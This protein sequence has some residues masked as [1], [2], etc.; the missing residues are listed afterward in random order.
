MR[1]KLN[2]M[3]WFLL[4]GKCLH[5][6]ILA[7]SAGIPMNFYGLFAAFIQ[8]LIPVFPI[9]AKL[10]RPKKKNLAILA[11]LQKRKKHAFS[12]L[13][14]FIQKT[15]KRSGIAGYSKNKP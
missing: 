12:Y 5:F 11:K 9:L 14:Q 10:Q 8:I 7:C 6:L 13:R 3:V 4:L 15:I 1:L 2:G